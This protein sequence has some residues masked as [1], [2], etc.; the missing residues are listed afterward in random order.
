MYYRGASLKD[1]IEDVQQQQGSLCRATGSDSCSVV[2]MC[3]AGRASSV[4]VQAQQPEAMSSID[5]LSYDK[6]TGE[7]CY[8]YGCKTCCDAE[9]VGAVMRAKDL[10]PYQQACC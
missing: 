10:G 3:C 6:V 8:M 4:R 1:L 9:A 7:L 5:R 2:P